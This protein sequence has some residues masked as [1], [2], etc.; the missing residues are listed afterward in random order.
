ML[1][2]VVGQDDFAV[3]E[4][5]QCGLGCLTRHCLVMACDPRVTCRLS[6]FWHASKTFGLTDFWHDK[7]VNAARRIDTE[8]RFG[9]SIRFVRSISFGTFAQLRHSKEYGYRMGK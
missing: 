8:R 7:S 6:R 4:A 5:F 3:M 1:G 9:G 2:Q